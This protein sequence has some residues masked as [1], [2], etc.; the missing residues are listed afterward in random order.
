MIIIDEIPPLF[1]T[2]SFNNL[3]WHQP[4]DSGIIPLT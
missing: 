4:G 3:L 2:I 1:T